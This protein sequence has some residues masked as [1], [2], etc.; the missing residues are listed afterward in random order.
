MKKIIIICAV[1]ALFLGPAHSDATG[2]DPNTS[3][4]PNIN[5]TLPD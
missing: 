3:P 4:D 1:L 2:A 5:D